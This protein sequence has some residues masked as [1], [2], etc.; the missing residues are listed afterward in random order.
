MVMIA[1]G[2][3][4]AIGGGKKVLHLFVQKS[5]RQDVALRHS[6]PHLKSSS[7]GEDILILPFLFYILSPSC[8]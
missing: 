7:K 4:F 6:A 3:L 5:E 1:G 8:F 2:G